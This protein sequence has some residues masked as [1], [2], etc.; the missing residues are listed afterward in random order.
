MISTQSFFIP[1]QFSS[2]FINPRTHDPHN[3]GTMRKSWWFLF[4]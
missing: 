2:W 3:R 1:I 4:I